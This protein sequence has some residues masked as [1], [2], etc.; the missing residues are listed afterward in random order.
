[1]TRPD[2]R[3]FEPKRWPAEAIADPYPIYRHYRE[4]DPVHRGPTIADGGG[5]WYVFRHDD[6]TDVLS[7]PHYGRGGHRSLAAIPPDCQVLRRMVGNWLVFMDP[8]QHGEL[9]SLLAG[10]FSAQVV[11]GLR[12]RIAEIAHDLVADIGRAPAFDLVDD[13]AAP[14][15]ILVISELLGVPR[16]NRTWLRELAMSLQEGSSGR[17]GDYQAAEAAATDLAGYFRWEAQRRRRVPRDDL[18][19]AL[20]RAGQRGVLTDDAI[21]ATCVH[22]LTAGHETTTNLISKSV[23]ALLRNPDVLAEFRASPEPLPSAV[24]EFIRYDSPVQMV[25]RW[26][27]RPDTLRGRDIRCGDKVV[28]VLGS[29]NRDP[30]LVAEPDTIRLWRHPSRHCGFGG[31]VHRCLGAAMARTETAIAL[32]VLFERLPGLRLTDEQV[33]FAEDMVFHGPRHLV[34]GTSGGNTDA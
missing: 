13:F 14:L 32:T 8:P 9:R 15:P 30:D 28:L 33:R 6:V 22:L 18:I 5:T 23:L 3:P 29:A 24:D 7:N 25:T 16:N 12:T 34:L 20:V 27:Y 19:T 21:T 4:N 11:N 26:A 1:M 17:S 31:G 2:T 10:R